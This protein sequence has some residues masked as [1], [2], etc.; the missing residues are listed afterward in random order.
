M[1]KSQLLAYIEYRTP[2]VYHAT[3]AALERLD[4]IQIKFLHDAGVNETD[5]LIHFNLAPLRM[6]RDIAMLGML[7]RAAIGKG[8]S[9][10]LQLFKRRPGS[11]RLEDPYEDLTCAPLIK[12]S[13]FGLVKVYNKLGSGAHNI[14]SVHD[15]QAYLQGRAKQL[16]MTGYTDKW[17]R[18]YCP[19]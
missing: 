8:P 13:A 10:L 18:L 11:F 3:R 9:Q 6:R 14:S 19:R 5:A 15:F 12:R 1:Y 16:V 7:H 17:D 2:A 4:N